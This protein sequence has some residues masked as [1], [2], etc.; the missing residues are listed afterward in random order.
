M[1]IKTIYFKCSHCQKVWTDIN[2]A[3]ECEKRCNNLRCS[4]CGKTKDEVQYIIE[5]PTVY[6]CNEC[7]YMCLDI[8]IEKSKEKPFKEETK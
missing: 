4:F 3:E 6:I 8:L 2:K 5:G 7:V 1:P